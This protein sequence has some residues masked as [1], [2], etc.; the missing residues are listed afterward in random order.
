LKRAE[1]KF[2]QLIFILLAFTGGIVAGYAWSMFHYWPYLEP[3][4]S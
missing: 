4:L 2:K 1:R 3:I